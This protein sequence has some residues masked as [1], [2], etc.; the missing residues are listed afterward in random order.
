M[1][2]QQTIK[3]ALN[4]PARTGEPSQNENHIFN[5]YK[6]KNMT[7]Y[8]DNTILES[9]LQQKNRVDEV[10]GESDASLTFLS[11]A[12]KYQELG[13]S[14]IPCEG[15]EGK[16]PI[17]S[18]KLYQDRKAPKKL[19]ETWFSG[20]DK[21]IAIVTGKLS[22]IT[23]VDCDDLTLSLED[24]LLEFGETPYIVRTPK[25][26]F[27]LYY[28]HNDEKSLKGFKG[29]KIYVR[30]VGGCIVCP[31]SCNPLLGAIYSVLRGCLDD[32]SCLPK[33]KVDL[34]YKPQKT[35]IKRADISTSQIANEG[36]R[37]D[38]LFYYCMSL[39]Q[40]DAALNEIEAK[41][42]DFNEEFCNPP[43]DESEVRAVFNSVKGYIENGTLYEKG[44]PHIPY[45]RELRRPLTSNANR[46]LDEVLASHSL[47]EEPFALGTE[48]FGKYLGWAT[49]TFKKARNELLDHGFIKRIHR[50]GKGKRDPGLYKLSM[51]LSRAFYNYNITYI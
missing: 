49:K 46:L 10:R 30:G 27:H 2:R 35:T 34:S 38:A 5:F 20:S 16:K 39:A 29:R 50:G 19:I 7:N 12:L 32:L 48:G 33:C 26:G 17:V 15:K 42:F 25:G 13:L 28:R 14:I 11:I 41:V 23:V 43:L 1:L 24:L 8:T 22:N 9:E 37:N 36:G 51:N 6:E 31:P 3:K 18:W 4:E 40:D 45:D 47:R 21:N 44:V